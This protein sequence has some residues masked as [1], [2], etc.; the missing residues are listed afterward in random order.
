MLSRLIS[1]LAP[2]LCAA[3]GVDAAAAPPLCRRCRVALGLERGRQLRVGSP[4]F[5]CWAACGYEGPG[6]ALVRALKFGG[7]VGLAD[8]MAA[9][10][11]AHTPP[12]LLRGVIVPA[13]VHP[14]HRRRR[15]VD[16][17]AVLA[18]ALARRLRLPVSACLARRGD[19]QPQVGRG[20][21]ERVRGPAGTVVV[22]PDVVAPYEALLVDDVVTTGATLAACADALRGAGSRRIAALVY[23]RTSGR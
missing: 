9:Q 4:A 14:E 7:R 8:A 21:S 22:R 17:A 23:A 20:R 16:H 15:G 6:G 3:C 10:I 2:P 13:P 12:G 11:A 18:Q 1:V 5:D 19:A